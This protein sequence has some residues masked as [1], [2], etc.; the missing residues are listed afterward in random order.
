MN[1]FNNNIMCKAEYL[2]LKFVIYIQN[3]YFKM[4]CLFTSFT[5]V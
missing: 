5:E 2:S 4:N 1:I 3:I